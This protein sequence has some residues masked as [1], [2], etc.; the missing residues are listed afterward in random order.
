MHDLFDEEDHYVTG[1]YSALINQTVTTI[2]Y[3][4]IMSQ[5]YDVMAGLRIIFQIVLI[6]Y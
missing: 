1:D 2:N 4:N 6:V 5:F 3:V